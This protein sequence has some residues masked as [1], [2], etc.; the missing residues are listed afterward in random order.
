MIMNCY[1]CTVA[2]ANTQML[3]YIF[4]SVF[5]IESYV[6]RF[7]LISFRPQF[8]AWLIPKNGIFVFLLFINYLVYISTVY[9]LNRRD[10]N[11]INLK[12]YSCHDYM[13]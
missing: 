2:V 11:Q 6:H 5:H 7:Q 8:F 12:T 1:S 9:I 4:S 3:S 13:N 10:D